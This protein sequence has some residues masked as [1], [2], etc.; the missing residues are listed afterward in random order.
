MIDHS[1]RVGWMSLLGSR[2]GCANTT[3]RSHECGARDA[4]HRARAESP[5]NGPAT[6]DARRP[7]R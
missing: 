1:L 6:H 5:G 2:N 3:L 4:P 7:R